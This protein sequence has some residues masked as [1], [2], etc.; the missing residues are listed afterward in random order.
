MVRANTLFDLQLI[1]YNKTNI[2]QDIANS[3]VAGRRS[4]VV[5]RPS[6]VAGRWSVVASHHAQ[7]QTNQWMYLPSATGSS[8]PATSGCSPLPATVAT[9]LVIVLQATTT[10]GEDNTNGDDNDEDNDDLDDSGNGDSNCVC[11]VVNGSDYDN[12]YG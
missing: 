4:L 7:Q 12:C 9:T 10:M 6:P 2:K 3:P 11:V 8:L 1:K 5:G